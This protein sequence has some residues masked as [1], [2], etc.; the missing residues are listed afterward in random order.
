VVAETLI[1]LLVLHH[2]LYDKIVCASLLQQLFV[3]VTTAVRQCYN[4]C[5]SVLQQLFVTVTTA[6]RHCYN[7]CSSVLQQLFVSVTTA[8]RQCYNSSS[9]VLQQL[10]VSVR[11]NEWQWIYLHSFWGVTQRRGVILY[12]RFGT[13]YR[14]HL[15]GLRSQIKSMKFCFIGSLDPWRWDRY[16]VPQRR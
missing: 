9:S 2:L 11:A 4:S 3:S 16:V 14:F 7:S 12:R 1:A 15:Q 6:V 13:T 5:S 8:V 10:F